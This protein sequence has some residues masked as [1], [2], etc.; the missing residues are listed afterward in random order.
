MTTTC[1]RRV[2]LVLLLLATS[3]APAAPSNVGPMLGPS[4]NT[5]PSMAG[6][7]P[8]S[9]SPAP[10][11]S[12]QP[13][14]P[15]DSPPPVDRCAV[16]EPKVIVPKQGL[17]RAFDV[18]DDGLLYWVLY[19]SMK[20]E[21][22]ILSLDLSDSAATPRQV[23]KVK[24]GGDPGSL[25]VAR[26]GF[27]MA[28]DDITHGVCGSR[29]VWLG[30]TATRAVPVSEPA[31]VYGPKRAEGAEAV[32]ATS[33]T[34]S[35]ALQFVVAK[36][37]P[38][39]GLAPLPRKL[40]AS[41]EAVQHAA[42]GLYLA[43][44]DGVVI[45]RAPDGSEQRVAQPVFGSQATD[46]RGVA[47]HGDDVYL[48]SG[49]ELRKLDLFRIPRTGGDRQPLGTFDVQTTV[50]PLYATGGGA[51]LHLLGDRGAPDR[52]LL[53]D[54]TGGCPQVELPIPDLTRQVVVDRD[55]VYVLRKEGIVAASFAA[56]SR[57]QIHGD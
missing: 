34:Y 57:A 24:M 15:P 19:D 37:P 26:D 29:V 7:A 21:T 50:T 43:L 31:C 3:C 55:V 13:T 53:I 9:E 22:E 42:D 6:S 14:V 16:S 10:A 32:W 52:L 12:A 51:V 27:W 44:E 56:R 54:P 35:H 39:G 30:R 8:P 4:T 1:R 20:L 18:G 11:A 5:S 36:G 38:P 47:V 33:K 48:A 46:S 17:I 23:V 25:V 45:R 2:G 40:G 41:F 28:A 49:R